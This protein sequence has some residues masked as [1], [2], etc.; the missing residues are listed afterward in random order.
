[1]HVSSFDA[2]VVWALL[3]RFILAIQWLQV[4]ATRNEYASLFSSENK[5]QSLTLGRSVYSLRGRPVA[6]HLD[7]PVLSIENEIL[8]QVEQ[9]R[10]SY[11]RWKTGHADECFTGLTSIATQVL[12]TLTRTYG[13]RI[14][15]ERSLHLVYLCALRLTEHYS[16]Y[17][18]EDEGCSE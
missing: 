16:T 10:D 7:L 1:M 17:M 12:W 5:A 13:R 15:F 4:L 3:R 14:G 8:V 6:S 2:W 18:D 11:G 9:H